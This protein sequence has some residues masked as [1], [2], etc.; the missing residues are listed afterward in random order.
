MDKQLRVTLIQTRDRK[1]LVTVHN[2]PGESADLTPAQMRALAVALVAAADESE[3]QP[4]DSRHYARVKRS[5]DIATACGCR[6]GECE[7]KTGHRCRM[8]DEVR[9]GSGAQ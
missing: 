5:Y 4:M 7:S 9:P 6:I 3:M 2:L 8:A 1:P